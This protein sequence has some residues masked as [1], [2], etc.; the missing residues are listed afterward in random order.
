[1]FSLKRKTAKATSEPF[2]FIKIHQ[3]EKV[4]SDDGNRKILEAIKIKDEGNDHFHTK[5]YGKAKGLYDAAVNTLKL[6]DVKK[7]ARQL[8]ICYQNRASAYEQL[9]DAPSMIQDAAKAIETDETYAKGYYRRARGFIMERK[10]YGAFQD[11]MWA[12]ILERFTNE[13]Y[14]KMAADMNARFSKHLFSTINI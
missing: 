4:L 2:V 7:C 5:N 9:R 1:M 13:A 14:N 8:A 3:G 6:L 12:C 11:V 10:F